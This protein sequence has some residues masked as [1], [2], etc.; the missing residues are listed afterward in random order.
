MKS[1]LKNKRNSSN[2]PLDYMRM[3]KA[4]RTALQ[5]KR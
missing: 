3:K 5:G 4:H 1:H 2:K